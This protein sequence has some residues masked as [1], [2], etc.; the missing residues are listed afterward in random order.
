[1]RRLPRSRRN[2]K[3]YV[4]VRTVLQYTMRCAVHLGHEVGTSPTHSLP[5][6]V[7]APLH[8]RTHTGMGHG[9]LGG[10]GE[11]SLT[12]E[13]CY[14]QLSVCPKG[15]AYVDESGGFKED[16]GASRLHA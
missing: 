1:M 8:F 15:G 12:S 13:R 6:V 3:K 11:G 16:D 5:R 4:R 9:S 7:T 14:P 10:S 2:K